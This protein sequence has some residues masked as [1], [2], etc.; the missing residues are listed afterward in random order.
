MDLHSTASAIIEAALQSAQ[1]DEAVRRALDAHPLHGDVY[2]VAIGKAA[3]QMARAAVGCLHVKDGVVITK[4]GVT[5][6]GIFPAF[7]SLKPRIPFRTPTVIVPRKPPSIWSLLCVQTIRCFFSFP[8][9]VR[10]SLKSRSF[11]TKKWPISPVNC[12]PAAPDIQEINTLRKRL[13]AVKGGKFG[14]MCKPARVFSIVLSDII[15]DPLDMIASGPA[16]PDRS[17][18]ADA[19]DIIQ[20]YRLKL[21]DQAMRLMQTD[22]PAS[23]DNVETVVTG[24]VRQLCRTAS[25][26]CERLG[27]EPRFLTASLNCEAREAGRF[28]AAIA[29]DNANPD[30][31]IAYIL[32]GETVVHLTGHGKGGRN[33]ELALAAAE[34]IADLPNVAVFSVGSDGTDGPTDASGRLCRRSDQSRVGCAGH[35]HRRCASR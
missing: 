30:H 16:Y 27:I 3:W 17:T 20:K 31:P 12:S 14:D 23:L 26:Q 1:P 9:A 7:A 4:Y 34:G 29:K 11:L 35:F 32:G 28:L 24:S 19:L 21:S 25:E 6:R 2:L 10:R 33:Q 22:L 8:A 18:S 13:S 15:G 5:P